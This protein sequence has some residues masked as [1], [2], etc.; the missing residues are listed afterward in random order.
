ME[1]TSLTRFIDYLTEPLI[2]SKVIVKRASIPNIYRR[3]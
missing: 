3:D 2:Y 1:I